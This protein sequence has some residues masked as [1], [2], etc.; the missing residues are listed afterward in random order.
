MQKKLIMRLKHVTLL[1]LISCLHVFASGHAQRISLSARNSSMLEVMEQIEKQTGY[2]FWLQ[3]DLLKDKS[4]VTVRIRNGSLQAVLDQLFIKHGLR[5]TIIDKIIVVTPAGEMSSRVRKEQLPAGRL[6]NRP[7]AERIQWP[8]RIEKEERKIELLRP[9]EHEIKGKVLDELGDGLPGVS[10]VVKGTQRGISTDV[11]GQFSLSVPGENTVLVFSFVGYATQ[12]I[13]VGNRSSLEVTMSPD[14]K[15]LEELVVIGYGVVK[16]SDL[17]GS[18]SQVKAKELN[19]FPNA[20]VLQSLSG[21]APG[22]HIRQSSGAPGADISVRVR[23]GNSIQGANDPLYVIDGFPVNRNPTHLNN[24]DIESL[25]ILKDASATAIYGSRGANGVVIITTKKGRKGRTHVDF[26]TSYSSQKLIRKL[27]LMNA[28]EYAQFYNEQAVNDNIKPF[29][30]QQDIDNLGE[31]FDWQDFVFQRAPIMTSALNVSGGNEKTLFSLSGSVF[32]QQGIVKGSNYNRYSLQTNISHK[33][34]DKFTIDFTSTVSRLASERKDSGG[35]SRGNSMIAAA[36]SA[37]PTLTPYNPDGSYT[38]LSTAYPFIATDIR[39]PINFINEQ[40]S[41][42][43]AN[44]LLANLGLSYKITPD[45]TLKVA[46]GIEN[47]D[48]R[49]DNYTTRK[50]FNSQGI[51]NVST[52]QFT[53]LLN[54][55]TLN[56][57]K[58]FDDRHSLSAVAGMTFQDFRSTSLNAGGTGFLSDIF[59][60]YN[61]GAAANQNIATSGYSRSVLVSFLG[62]VNYAYDSRYLLTASIRRDGASVYSPGSKWGYFPSAA[63]AW[64][65]SNEDFLADN[66]VVS[67]LKLRTSWGITGSPGVTSYMTLNNLVPDRT[68][69]NDALANTFSPGTRLPGNLKWE[70]TAQFDAGL[71]IGLFGNRLLLTADYYMKNT[72]DLLSVV[73]LPSSLG[74]TSTIMNVGKVQNK[75]IELGADALIVKRGDLA[76]DV[77]AN[78]SFNRNKVVSLYGGED[79]L[80][81]NIGVIIVND[82][83]GILREGRPI[84]QFWGYKEAGYDSNG[85]IVF[86]DINEDGTITQADKTYIG[87]ANPNFI[88]GLSSNLTYKGFEFNMFW[89]GSQGNDIFNAS[90]ITNTMDYGFGLN[91]PRSVFNNHWTPDSPD[92]QYPKISL[93][94]PVRMSERFIEDGSYLRLKNISVGYNLT[95]GLIRSKALR[96]LYVYVSGQNLLT[97]TGY[98][99]WDPETNFRIDHNSYPVAKSVTAGV[100]IGF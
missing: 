51:A 61:I 93:R 91:M 48:D 95:S 65:V 23:G 68:I 90:A 7:L 67:D 99:W 70:T 8:E 87:D 100:R 44:V 2:T 60:S 15:S 97:F 59:E 6:E 96:N 62:R 84:G 41:T 73:S 45:L 80:R 40:S 78:I 56:Y 77:N 82:A 9:A 57:I 21:R 85:F 64:R 27:D 69:F 3:T 72:R 11:D 36:I 81:D 32:G 75:G 13:I 42:I 89:Q 19:A 5:Y 52:G 31:G 43:T 14:L 34:S 55:N 20:N 86:K 30:S 22:V 25:E 63:F 37:P 76:W 58:T 98:S 66:R 47:R 24:S 35:G 10:V 4:R 94:S 49:T 17:T 92:A 71:D 29:F 1:V 50:F 38:V 88:Y 79:I 18:V 83:T 16:K 28:K 33:A 54:E 12:E 39:N 46:G 53:S 74:Y 26:E